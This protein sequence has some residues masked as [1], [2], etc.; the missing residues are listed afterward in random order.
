VVVPVGE[1]FSFNS[2]LQRIHPA[3]SRIGT[4][5]ADTPALF[6][7]FDILARGKHDLAALPLSQRRPMLEAFAD[8]GF[9]NGQS[10][11]LSPATTDPDRALRWL[12]QSG[13]GSDGVITKRVDLAY[14]RRSANLGLGSSSGKAPKRVSPTWPTMRRS[15]T[16]QSGCFLS[17]NG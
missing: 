5:S 7:A 13:G 15:P 17:N 6:L 10:F 14:Q 4:L 2:L 11:R 16:F 9:G 1:G 8:R 12:A 3:A